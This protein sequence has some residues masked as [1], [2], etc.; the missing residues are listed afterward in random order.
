MADLTSEQQE[1]IVVRLACYAFP[2]EI[3]AEFNAKFDFKPSLSQIAY[4]DPM[5]AQ[6]S[7]E[8]KQQWK[9]LFWKT[10]K[11]H[12]REALSKKS[13]AES[14]LSPVELLPYCFRPRAGQ[15]QVGFESAGAGR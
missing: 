13:P 10:R 12:D 4:Y 14:G 5:G 6:G 8:L 11:A 7:R 15:N 1:L 3:Q 9:D 2:T